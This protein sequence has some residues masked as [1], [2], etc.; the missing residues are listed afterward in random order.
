[1]VVVVEEEVVVIVVVAELVACN[2]HGLVS[3]NSQEQR[4][5]NYYIL[6]ASQ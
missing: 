5:S 1:V 2:L 6:T 4:D 3:G